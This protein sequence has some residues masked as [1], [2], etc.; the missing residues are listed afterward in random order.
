MPRLQVKS[1]IGE[2]GELVGGVWGEIRAHGVPGTLERQQVDVSFSHC[3][4]LLSSSLTLF[5]KSMSMSS[6]KDED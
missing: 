6:G 3:Y 5:L 4:F 2:C 1:L